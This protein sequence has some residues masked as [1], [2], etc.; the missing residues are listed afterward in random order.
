M[1]SCKCCYGGNNNVLTGVV[2]DGPR[3]DDE[4]DTGVESPVPDGDES[5]GEYQED[6]G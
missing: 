6:S 2:E 1:W 4:Y 3:Q 5:G